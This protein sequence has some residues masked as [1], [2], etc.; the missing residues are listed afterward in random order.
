MMKLKRR[1]KVISKRFKCNMMQCVHGIYS[2]LVNSALRD[3]AEQCFNNRVKKK[4]EALND[5]T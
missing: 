5:K 2:R 3:Y 1:V 4:V